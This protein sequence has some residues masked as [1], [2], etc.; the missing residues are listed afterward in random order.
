MTASSRAAFVLTLAS[1]AGGVPDTCARVDDGCRLVEQALD[2]DA[3]GVPEN[4]ATWTHNDDGHV[5]VYEAYRG[6]T[7]V[8]RR[9]STWTG[10]LEATRDDDQDGDGVVDLTT[11]A[12]R[13]PLAEGGYRDAFVTTAGGQ[14]YESGWTEFDAR[15]HAQRAEIIRVTPDGPQ[16]ITRAW[17]WDAAGHLSVYVQHLPPPDRSTVELST[18][19]D[20]GRLL[21]FES[22]FTDDDT[23]LQRTTTA[24]DGCN[25][26]RTVDYAADATRTC[27]MTYGSD[28]LQTSKTCFEDGYPTPLAFQIFT[29]SDAQ[30]HQIAYD[31]DHDLQPDWFTR[32]TDNAYGHEVLEEEIDGDG[33]TVLSTQT[34]TWTCP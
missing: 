3:D 25:P 9:V 28:G 33:V 30:H 16:T 20:A 15:G 22:R 5:L 26:I 6:A 1:C 24:W 12:T 8:W 14:P 11:T 32:H 2:F 13:E 17:T 27:T 4:R 23:P 18:Y 10:D 31:S 19:D 21:A 7:R 34:S 29:W